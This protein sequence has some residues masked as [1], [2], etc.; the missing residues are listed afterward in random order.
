MVQYIV[1]QIFGAFIAALAVYG[2]YKQQ[3]DAIHAELVAGGAATQA[4]IF[5]NKG[6]A[7]VPALFVAEGQYLGWAFLNEFMACVVRP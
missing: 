3:L 4:I 2:Q 1:A 6:P 7:G 5:S